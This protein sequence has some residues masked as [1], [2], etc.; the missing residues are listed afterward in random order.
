MLSHLTIDQALA[1]PGALRG[2]AWL[3]RGVDYVAAWDLQRRLAGLRAVGE[4]G[5]VA[6]LLEHTPVYTAGPRSEPA[7]VLASLRAPLIETDRGGQLTYHGPGQLVGYPIVALAGQR[8]GPK[9]YVRAL[10]RLLIDVLVGHGI[11]AHAEEGATGVW[12]ARGKVAAIG[13]R[14]SRGVTMHGFALNVHTDLA[15]YRDIVPCGI[16]DRPVTSM[17]EIAGQRFDL[18][19]VAEAVALGLVGGRSGLRLRGRDAGAGRGGGSAG[20]NV[21][22]DP[23]PGE[24]A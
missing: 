10:E 4:I 8:I 20:G 12:T 9:A 19:G 6:L 23:V 21:L 11:E 2:V 1:V 17:E 7:H 22:A 24:E 13:V 5:D 15:A 3:G 18:L 16:T 14:V